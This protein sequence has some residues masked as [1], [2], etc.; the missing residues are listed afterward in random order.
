MKSSKIT[1][2]F[3]G[4]GVLNNIAYVVMLASA[5]SI[6]EGGTALVFLASIMPGFLVKLSRSVNFNDVNHQ[7]I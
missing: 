7:F 5:K 1:M 6:S 4:M 2:A 3:W